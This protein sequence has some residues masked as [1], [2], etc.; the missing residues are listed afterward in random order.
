MPAKFNSTDTVRNKGVERQAVDVQTYARD[1]I[2]A[3]VR[4]T[5]GNQCIPDILDSRGAQ[6]HIP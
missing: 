1:M 6:D 3:A 4:L 5:W 2:M